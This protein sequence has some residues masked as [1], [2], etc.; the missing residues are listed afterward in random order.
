VVGAVVAGPFH[1]VGVV[2]AALDDPGIGAVPAYRVEVLLAGDV[3]FDVGEG[4]F[5]LFRGEMPLG[6]RPGGG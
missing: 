5:W 2:A 1:P 6:Q 4:A 3:G